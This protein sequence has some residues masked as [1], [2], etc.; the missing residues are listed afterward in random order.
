MLFLK[1]GKQGFEPALLLYPLFNLFLQSQLYSREKMK[2]ISGGKG[3]KLGSGKRK[4]VSEMDWPWV[5]DF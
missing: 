5:M 1:Q 4:Q 3:N 2:E